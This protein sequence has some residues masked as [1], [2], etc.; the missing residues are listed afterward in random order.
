MP[1][2]SPR[3]V[4]RQR[5][6]RTLQ[7]NLADRGCGSTPVRSPRHPRLRPPCRDEQKRISSG[8]PHIAV[9]TRGERRHLLEH[10]AWPRTPRCPS[11][12]REMATSSLAPAR[13]RSSTD[14]GRPAL[15]RRRMVTG[16]RGPA[17]RRHIS[18]NG[19]LRF[20]CWTGRATGLGPQVRALGLPG[21]QRLRP[22][23]I[24]DDWRG[25]PGR[26]APSLQR[27]PRQQRGRRSLP[28]AGAEALSLPHLGTAAGS[29]G[30]GAAGQSPDQPVR[31]REPFRKPG[32]RSSSQ[33]PRRSPGP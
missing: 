2:Y 24:L 5:C 31:G 32:T 29:R 13:R 25:K 6:D 26:R 7:N 3:P 20:W 18:F 28:I 19:M 16:T 1:A 21:R 12:S 27:R 22:R 23:R 9:P 30:S 10:A 8:R 11:P 15:Y 17:R 4:I 33:H 14:P